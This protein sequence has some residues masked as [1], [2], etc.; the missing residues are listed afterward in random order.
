[1]PQCFFFLDLDDC[2]SVHSECWV[3]CL[4]IKRHRGR[5]CGSFAA[6]RK[7]YISAH[8]LLTAPMVS[9]ASP[10]EQWLLCEVGQCLM[11]L[12]YS[13]CDGAG[14]V[15]PGTALSSVCCLSECHGLSQVA[16]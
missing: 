8:Q 9:L 7:S 3:F 15:S 2:S 14:R 13:L 12:M 16:V 11:V 1:M 5:K 4:A 6:H 10:E